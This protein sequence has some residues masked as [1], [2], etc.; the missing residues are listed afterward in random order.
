MNAIKWTLST[1][2]GLFLASAALGQAGD[3]RGNDSDAFRSD[4]TWQEDRADD[5]SEPRTQ[6]PYDSESRTES[7]TESGS[8]TVGNIS[9]EEQEALQQRR[10]SMVFNTAGFGPAGL[11][12]MD[13][14][15]I[16][17]NFYAGRLWEV[18]RN[19]AVKALGEVYSDLSNASL[20]SLNLGANFYPFVEEYTPYL[21]ASL[22]FGYGFQGGE[23][24]FGFDLAASIGALLF[25][26][27]DV[28][29]NVEGKSM[30]LLDTRTEGDFP[31]AWA[32]RVGILF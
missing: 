16:S 29:M 18:N 4:T 10:R 28:Q 15:G 23:N 3:S 8:N 11:R 17:Y 24:P 22:G 13:E 6:D 14:S 2:L 25:R 5:R 27:A 9:E 19:A 30:L 7:R 20:L 31:V 32:A 26:T 1:T 12:N 21:G